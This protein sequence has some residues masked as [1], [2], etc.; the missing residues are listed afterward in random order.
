ED[1]S[2]DQKAASYDI[3]LIGANGRGH[4]W[5]DEM[6]DVD[7]DEAKNI[8]VA[9]LAFDISNLTLTDNESSASLIS[10]GSSEEESDFDEPTT[11]EVFSKEVTQTLERAFSEG[12]TVEIASLEL[13]TLRMASNTTFHDTRTVVIPTIFDQ[14]NTDKLLSSTKDIL[15]RWG[16]LIG[17]LVHSKADQVD[18]LFILQE[19]CANSDILNKT[20]APSLRILYE[21][22][23]IGEDAILEWYYDE[24]SNG[25]VVKQAYSKLR[26]A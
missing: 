9:A 22:D 4:L 24:R 1:E 15:S 3:K 25:G 16:L 13:N 19:F 8:K 6:S 20:F 23:V 17:K 14:I 7:D 5:N 12:H 2:V 10:D 26:D 11:L 18:A 21:I